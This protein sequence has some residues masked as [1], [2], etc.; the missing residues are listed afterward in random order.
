MTVPFMRAYTELLVATCHRRGAHA[1]GGMGAF[2]PNRR[3]AEVN[4]RAI[5]AVAADKRREAADGF[6]GRGW[7]TP[8]SSRGAGRV[9]P[10]SASGRTSSSARATASTSRPRSSST[11]RRTGGEVTEAGVRNNIAVAWRYMAAWLG[12]TGAVA[13]DD[14]MEDAAAAENTR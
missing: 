7:R 5:A 10:V 12:G 4:D 1:I 9:R 13:I 3:D 2:I 11:A 8:T 6:D 14:L